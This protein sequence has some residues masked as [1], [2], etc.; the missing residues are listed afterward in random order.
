[1]LNETESGENKPILALIERCQPVL[2]V[3]LS[4]PSLS[5]C[6]HFFKLFRRHDD[7]D[8]MIGNFYFS[9]DFRQSDID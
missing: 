3:M 1:M 7:C 4:K 5:F 6:F 8:W 9:F 2:A